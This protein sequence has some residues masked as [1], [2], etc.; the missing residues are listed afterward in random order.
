[1]DLVSE[2]WKL[3]IELAFLMASRIDEHRR[4]QDGR[5]CAVPHE[6]ACPFTD[7]R[8]N[9]STNFEMRK[10]LI[11]LEQFLHSVH[12]VVEVSEGRRG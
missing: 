11:D 12:V 8:T 6:V 3:L 2:V 1:M 5:I 7:S 10:Y 9:W 4:N